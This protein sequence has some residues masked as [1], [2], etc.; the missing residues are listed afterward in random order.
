M[1]RNLYHLGI[2]SLPS[3]YKL[4]MSYLQRVKD[5]LLS[6]LRRV[7]KALF[8]SQENAQRRIMISLLVCIAL[9]KYKVSLQSA[10]LHKLLVEMLRVDGLAK[11]ECEELYANFTDVVTQLEKSG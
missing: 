5:V 2:S 9:Q 10:E 3:H 4:R 1:S 11:A 8:E 6:W 7:S